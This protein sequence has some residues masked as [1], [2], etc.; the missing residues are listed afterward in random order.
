[1]RNKSTYIIT[2]IIGLLLVSFLCVG[3]GSSNED[4][5]ERLK[6]KADTAL[7]FCKEKGMNTDYCLLINMKIHSGKKRFFLWDFKNDSIVSSSLCAHGYGMEST[8]STPVFSNVSGSYCTSLGKYK[9]GI[10]SYSKWGI[11]VHYKMH[12]LEETNSNAFDRIIVLH[13]HNPITSQE[14]YPFHLPLGFSQGCPVINNDV[15]KQLDALLK[16][17]KKSLLLWIYYE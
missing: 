1:M 9:V 14:I 10:R 2:L 8:E 16:T 7:L 5:Y 12:G 13:S 3:K 15:M 4:Q 6:A 17:Q 11:N